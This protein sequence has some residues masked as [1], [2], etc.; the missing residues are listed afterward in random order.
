MNPVI[1]NDVDVLGGACVADGQ[2]KVAIL[3]CTYNGQDYLAEQL[4]SFQSQSHVSWEVWASDDGS[5]DGTRAI[6][7]AYRQKWPT[8]R[9]SVHSGPA[10]GTVA[11][12][13]SLTCN[14]SIDA[15]YY[16][17]SDQDDVW[18]ADKLERA[19]QWLESIPRNIP[20]LY[21][22][23]TRLVDA[24][25]H[26]FGFSP[27]F[28]KPPSFANA[29]VQNIG[30]G[31]TMVFNNALRA[32]LCEAGKDVSVISH[33]WWSYIVAAGCGGKVFYDRH[34]SLRY[35]QHGG[36]QVGMNSTW[37]AR[38]KRIRMLWAGLFRD[39]N[40]SNIACL[41]KLRHKLTPESCET[42]DCFA[43]ARKMS[44]VP[45]LIHLKRSGI[46]RQTLYGNL[47]LVVAAIFGKI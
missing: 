47:G 19:V 29:I 10:A 30:G 39:W 11:N 31:N 38:C 44:L 7:D 8:G 5:E 33:D 21:C 41:C 35:R 20:A 42:L 45:R 3:L 9:L 24:E 40:D 12:F 2:P 13:L 32:L 6:L 1:S 16:A 27:L 17:Y 28:S 46:Y 34:P 23:R 43:S 18:D 37:P 25:N 14:T 22:S 26:E 4:D 15:E 36:N